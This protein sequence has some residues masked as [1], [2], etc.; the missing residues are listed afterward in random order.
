MNMSSDMN[1]KSQLYGINTAIYLLRP[2]AK[3]EVTN[4]V[5]TRWD[6]PRPCPTW[7]EVLDT[8]EKIKKFEESIKTIYL[9]EQMSKENVV[10]IST[11][12]K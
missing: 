1:S 9:P 12:S 3:W 11:Q 7:D 2:G 8:M 10:I 6:D 5:F 4:G